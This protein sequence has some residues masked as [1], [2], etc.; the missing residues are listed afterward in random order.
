MLILR[1]QDSHLV[2]VLTMPESSYALSEATGNG[3]AK[4]I[5]SCLHLG[6]SNSTLLGKMS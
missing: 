6:P 2:R 5:L 1:W 3:L 4:P